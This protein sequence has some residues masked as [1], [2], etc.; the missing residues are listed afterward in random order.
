[1]LKK[2][3][4]IIGG[5]GYIG[6]VLIENLLANKFEIICYDSQI[7]GNFLKKFKK[8]KFIKDDI[9]NFNKYNFKNVNSIIHLA[10]IA[11]DIIYS[12]AFVLKKE[13]KQYLN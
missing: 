2:K 4:L 5:C 11:N 13:S 7:Y 8:I 12:N 3:I 6:T 1:M 9:F 10:N